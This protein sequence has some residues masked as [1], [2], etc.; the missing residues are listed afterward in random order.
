[1][2]CDH[3]STN[4]EWHPQKEEGSNTSDET[5]ALST[6][7]PMTDAAVAAS[8]VVAGMAMPAHRRQATI[9]K[10]VTLLMKSSSIRPRPLP[11]AIK[12]P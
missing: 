1:M 3:C 2:L 8:A 12:I 7:I 11:P 4:A 10:R 9:A 6:G 5:P